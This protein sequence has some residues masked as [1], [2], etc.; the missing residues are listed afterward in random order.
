MEDDKYNKIVSDDFI[1]QLTDDQLINTMLALCKAASA[2]NPQKTYQAITLAITNGL[3]HAHTHRCLGYEDMAI[4]FGI[5]FRQVEAIIDDVKELESSQT[6]MLSNVI[7]DE[8][9][10]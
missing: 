6:I 5:A 3:F 1:N 7:D 4:A 2:K 8:V 10:H 9:Y